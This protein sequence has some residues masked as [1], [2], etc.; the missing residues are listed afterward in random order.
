MANV[1]LVWNGVPD[2][3]LIETL[4]DHQVT[5]VRPGDALEALKTEPQLVLL[6]LAGDGLV[7]LTEIVQ[8]THVPVL[9]LGHEQTADERT[10]AL[11]LGADDCVNGPIRP[12]ELKARVNVLLKRRQRQVDMGGGDIEVGQLLITTRRGVFADGQL[13]HLPP[14][15][16]RILKLLASAF[17]TIVS[18]EEMLTEV[19]HLPLDSTTNRLVDVHIDRLRGRLRDADVTNPTILTEYGLGYRLTTPT[20]GTP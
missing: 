3:V 17:D 8:Q 5:A 11:K 20:G 7:L 19:W 18:R 16:F 14:T 4:A 9:A 12:V 2:A 1:L 6:D 13:F 15:Q 10:L